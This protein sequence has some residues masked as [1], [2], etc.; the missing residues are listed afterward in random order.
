MQRVIGLDV[1]KESATFATLALDGTRLD[2]GTFPATPEAIDRFAATLTPEDTVVL[3]AT[4]NA[5]AFHDRLAVHAGE[6][7]IA[8]PLK[9]H[10]IAQAHL[11][12]DAVDATTLAQLKR[13]KFLPEVWIPDSRTRR[14]RS[15]LSHRELLTKTR[16]GWR[17]RI[18]AVLMRSL[19]KEPACADLFGPTGR[20]WLATVSLPPAEQ[21]QVASALRMHDAVVAEQAS[22]EQ[23]L[24]QEAQQHPDLPKLF[25]VPGL[26]L[27]TAMTLLAAIGDVR[28]FP[29]AKRLVGYLGLCPRVH[30]SGSTCYQGRITKAGPS[31]ARWMAVQAANQFV[32]ASASPLQAWYRRLKARKGHNRAIVAVARK[33]VA[34]VWHLLTSPEG[35]RYVQP[36]RH[37]AKLNQLRTR[38]AGGRHVYGPPKGTPP[39]PQAVAATRARWA[40]F[41]AAKEAAKLAAADREC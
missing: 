22:L 24:A 39:P 35:Y 4:T 28:R 11:K 31:S 7:A 25:A 37:Q 6:V 18:H 33:L 21:L 19:T 23:I 29:D 16:T 3:E 40:A 38:A 27:Y 8:N 5:W 10:L 20:R 2:A 14:W 32:R 15:L 36:T 1:H 30:Q 12:T 41:R 34:L 13:T 17:N 9:V 26:N